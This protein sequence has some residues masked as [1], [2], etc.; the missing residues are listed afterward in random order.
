MISD[1][2]R[3]PNWL[4][5]TLLLPASLLG[6]FLV[7]VLFEAI[8][9]ADAQNAH[10]P[11]L[12]IAKFLGGLAGAMAAFSIAYSFAPSRGKIVVIILGVLAIVSNLSAVHHKVV[13]KDYMGLLKT[14]G[15]FTACAVAWRKYVKVPR[16]AKNSPTIYELPYGK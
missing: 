4:R 2:D 9:S 11:I 5:W 13:Q 10:A 8:N 6:G 16:E 1:L 3:W 14:A 12:Y 7:A 15:E